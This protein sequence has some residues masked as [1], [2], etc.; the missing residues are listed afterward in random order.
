MRGIFFGL[1]ILLVSV[2]MAQQTP[3][4]LENTGAPIQLPFRCTDEDIEWAGLSCSA[5]EPC[6]MYLELTE[7]HPVGDKIF[8]AGN[9]H[10]SAVTLYS[11]LLSS[12]NAGKTWTEPTERIRG[13]GLDHIQFTDFESGWIS[14]EMLSPLPQ[15]PFFLISN[16][17]GKSWR[18]Q[19][20]FSDTRVGTIQQFYFASKTEGSFILDRGVGSEGG[21]YGLYESPNGG[22]SWIIKQESETPLRLRQ[23]AV[24]T[25]QW[26]VRADGRSKAFLVEHR[27]AEKWVP[28]ASF[29]LDLAACLPQA[30]EPEPPPDDVA[31]PNAVP[32][33][34]LPGPSNTKRPSR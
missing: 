10:A 20:V 23:P 6:P 11:V 18:R 34:R 33:L 25:V 32:V 17:G 29:A 2:A 15:D 13:A 24:P 30:A 26:R 14:G 28:V 1:I 5:D 4:V 22:D 3:T 19:P 21:R 31:A 12:Q 27:T 9:I 16:D 8:M 7:A